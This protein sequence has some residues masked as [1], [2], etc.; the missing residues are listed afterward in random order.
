MNNKLLQ[1]E[2]KF[3]ELIKQNPTPN[4]EEWKEIQNKL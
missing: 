1:P 3:F 2:S 4:E